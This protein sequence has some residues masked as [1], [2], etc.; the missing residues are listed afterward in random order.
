MSGYAYVYADSEKDAVSKFQ[1]IEADDL[2]EY[3][4]EIDNNVPVEVLT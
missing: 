3:V 1:E 2:L 4:D